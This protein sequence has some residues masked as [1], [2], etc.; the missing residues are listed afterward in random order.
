MAAKQ[1]DIQ[2]QYFLGNM[3]I[4]GDG[5]PRD[6][7][8]AYFWLGIA[9]SQ[10]ADQASLRLRQL[11]EEMSKQQLARVRQELEKLGF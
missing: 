8:R 2:A 6:P 9:A 7:S 4:T 1:N 3:Y 10:G 5:V 11:E